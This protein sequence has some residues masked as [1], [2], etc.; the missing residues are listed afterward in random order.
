MQK[1]IFIDKDGTLVKD[2]PYNVD[3]DLI[4]LENGVIRGLK[5]LQQNGFK[6]IVISNQA[7]V[8]YGFFKEEAL[9][10]VK[11][12][13]EELLAA[14]NIRL[15][16]FYYCPNHPEGIIQQY[17]LDCE[18]RK[19]AP[20]MLLKAAAELE[21][22]LTES[23]MIGDIL[24]DVEAGKRAGCK[25]ILID[26]GNETEWKWNQHNQPYY[27]TSSIDEAAE[28]ILQKKARLNFSGVDDWSHC[29]NILC[30]RADNMGD[31]LMSSPAIRALK[32]T[33]NARISVLTSSMAAGISSF[34]P[35]ID[36]T[37]VYNLPWVKLE[38][39]ERFNEI[40]ETLR[41]RSF[42]AV[43]IFSVYSQSPLPAAM[44]AYLADIPLRL[45][46]CRENP[47]HLLTNWLPDKE[48]YTE[49]KHQVRRDLDLVA[50]IGAFTS[51]EDLSLKI[52]PH[53]E[54][55]IIKKLEQT[56]VDINCPWLIAHAGVSEEKR[57]F[58]FNNWVQACKKIIA[59][60]GCQVLFT[61]AASERNLTEQL[62]QATGN[63][64]W[65]LA[66]LLSLEEFIALIKAAPLLISV[67]TG[68]V[69]I[70]AALGTPTIVLYALS[71]P[72]HFPWQGDGRVFTYS[73][74]AALQSKNEI[75]RFVNETYFGKYLAP[76]DGDELASAAM[77]ILAGNIEPMPA[78]PDNII[79]KPL[80]Q[81]ND[82][83]ARQLN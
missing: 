63:N 66:G 53:T 12:K 81:V 70:A 58:P 17:K 46:C 14:A 38:K 26:N 51:T 40:V 69:H 5:Q 62:Q 29:K 41:K 18:M 44:M 80:P 13:I 1:A 23:W 8:A 65:S 10:A 4:T 82:Q 19:P 9:S 15:D 75:I 31:L 64:S 24:H 60:T 7:G 55:F 50:E 6:L 35:E 42:D 16:G 79:T 27:T 77:E 2:I 48:P 74:P 3:P 59:D 33:F 25:T 20:G 30:I 11:S 22:D 49:I 43:V 21:I 76:I 73:V 57:Q 67:N 68:S 54:D 28:F 45:A 37:I 32:E 39:A 47:Y 72:Q 36:E 83:V 78:L 61:G 34:I 71:N 52:S 56:G